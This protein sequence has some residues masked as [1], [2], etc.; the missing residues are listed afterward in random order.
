MRDEVGR[1]IQEA[2]RKNAEEIG[3]LRSRLDELEDEQKDLSIALRALTPETTPTTDGEEPGVI[4]HTGKYRR[5]WEY[6]RA[7]RTDRVTLTFTEIEDDVLG[8]P[9]P[10]SSREHL[11]HWYGY[12]GSAVAR[13]IRDAG[14]KAT[15]V[16]LSRESVVFIRQ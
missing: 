11:P 6:L 15:N 9:L 10:P 14:W 3:V 2:M 8:F 7:Q 13:A 1:T 16:N 4:E 5:L 12:G